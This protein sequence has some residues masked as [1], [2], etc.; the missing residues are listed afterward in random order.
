[1]EW[2]VIKY[3]IS[4]LHDVDYVWKEIDIKSLQ[5]IV[6]KRS[7]FFHISFMTVP[8]DSMVIV[9]IGARYCM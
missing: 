2:A 5:S 1:M 6:D 8:M 9:Y 3:S 7:H 4:I